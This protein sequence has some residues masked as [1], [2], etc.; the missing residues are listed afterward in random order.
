MLTLVRSG[1]LL[2]RCRR[3]AVVCRINARGCSG[4]L[5]ADCRR[6]CC[7]NTRGTRQHSRTLP[8]ISR[9]QIAAM[10]VYSVAD[11]LR[12]VASVDV[13]ARG[14]RGVQSDFALRGASFGQVLVLVDGVRLNDSQSGHHNGDIP[15]PLDAVERIEVLHGPGRRC[16]APT[17]SA[18]PS[19][20]SRAARQAS[21]RLAATAEASACRRQRAPSSR[22]AALVQ[23]FAGFRRAIGGIHVQ[24]R[25]HY[26]VAAV[27]NRDS[28]THRRPL[29]A[30]RKEF[31]ANNFYGGNAPSREW[32]NQ[33]LVTVII[34]RRRGRL[35]VRPRRVVPHAWDRFLFNS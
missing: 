28:A 27:A 30:L 11:V 16:S 23:T 20:S 25:L 2:W 33:T 8:V 24:P 15:V 18:A 19:M 1:S 3:D 12:L 22:A 7:G 21:P 32:T 13:R 4:Y 9:E 17:P 10:P 26:D 35:A 6:D 29:S 14:E 34:D 31:G 5:S